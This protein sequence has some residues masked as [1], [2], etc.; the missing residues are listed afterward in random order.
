MNLDT[1]S[2]E[3]LKELTEKELTTVQI[4]N[5]IN[6]D[7]GGKIS[8]RLNQKLEENN[9]IEIV[10][11]VTPDHGG[12][13]TKRWKITEKGEER[14]KKEDISI[15]VS[16][17][18]VR[19]RV[20]SLEADIERLDNKIDQNSNRIDNRATYDKVD[21]SIDNIEETVERLRKAVNFMEGSAE[22]AGK[23]EAK[24]RVEEL[25][26]TIIEEK[27]KNFKEDNINSLIDDVQNIRR[28]NSDLRDTNDRLRSD[29][30]R[31]TE[32]VAE[33]EQQQDAKDE[34]ERG[35]ISRLLG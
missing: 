31:L 34:S 21:R 13:K 5:R 30:S 25:R 27:F 33:L 4:K 14:L 12:S 17:D 24:K 16:L 29:L 6:L 7:D 2:A 22:E 9:M 10:E 15:G 8:Y 26:E 35:L 18:D 3:I 23:R 20:E 32:R 19:D 28:E 1:D 11:K